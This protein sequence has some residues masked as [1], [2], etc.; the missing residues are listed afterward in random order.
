MGEGEKEGKLLE[1]GV[2]PRDG[3]EVHGPVGDEERE[4]AAGRFLRGL[5]QILLGKRREGNDCAEI[6]P[7]EIEVVGR[8]VHFI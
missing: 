4:S 1:D 6:E 5:D 7:V 2:L 8:K 3:A